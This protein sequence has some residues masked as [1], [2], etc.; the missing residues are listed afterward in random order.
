MVNSFR[1]NSLQARLNL[2]IHCVSKSDVRHVYAEV[3]TEDFEVQERGVQGE[4]RESV[5]SEKN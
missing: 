5:R 1:V 3:T 4:R 2:A